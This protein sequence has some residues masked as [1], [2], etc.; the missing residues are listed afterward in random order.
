MVLIQNF[1]GSCARKEF[2]LEVFLLE[3]IFALGIKDFQ[4]C[5]HSD[6]FDFLDV[7]LSDFHELFLQILNPF[8]QALFFI[9]RRLLIGDLLQLKEPLSPLCFH[10]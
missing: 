3:G 8:I 4:L 6:F 7:Q 5:L 9:P 2:L 1:T 10:A